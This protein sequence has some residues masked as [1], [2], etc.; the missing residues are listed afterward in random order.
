MQVK[1]A[2]KPAVS[3]AGFTLVELVAIIVLLGIL[4]AFVAPRF[5]GRNN[6]AEYT[7]RDHIITATRLAQQRAMYDHSSCYRLRVEYDGDRWRVGAQRQDGA[8]AYFGPD[9]DWGNGIT[10]DPSVTSIDA[11]I[12]FDGLG[13]ALDACGGNPVNTTLTVTASSTLSLCINPIGHVA[14]C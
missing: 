10:L 13:N 1:H 9:A 12:Y 2:E 8:W 4:T 7:A 6:F 11:A 3:A 5:L 14:A